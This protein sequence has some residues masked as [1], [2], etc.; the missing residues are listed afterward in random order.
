MKI[1]IISPIAYSLPPDKYGPWEKVVDT[2]A[3]GLYK[4]GVDITVISTSQ[5]KVPYKTFSTTDKT[6]MELETIYRFPLELHHLTQAVKHINSL[7]YDIVHN[8][9]N[10]YGV[11]SLQLINKPHVTTLHGMEEQAKFIYDQYSDTPFVSIS[12]ALRNY[13]PEL[14][15]IDTVYN[16]I[17]FDKFTPS[18]K[19]EDYLFTAARICHQKGI[20]NAIKL[21]KL[22]NKKLLIAGVKDDP[23]YFKNEIEPHIDNDKIIYVGNVGQSEVHNLVSKA[24]AYLSLIEWEEPFG[25][26][27]A[28]SIACGTPVIA[29]KKGSMPE[30]VK[31]GVSGILVDSVEEAAKKIES[32]KLIDPKKCRE[33]G[34][35]IFSIDKMIE[36]YLS[37]YDK[38]LKK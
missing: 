8:S 26:S 32:I 15:Y 3:T 1:A 6:T 9:L 23:E 25:L 10:W 19:K 35:N 4:K 12:N 20:H 34:Y 27:V 28:E 7:D 5:S 11:L 33:F 16:G 14:N 17:D 38:I 18:T 22:T 21:A 37:V 24:Y 36:G 31:E 2:L 30:L 29:T 13:K